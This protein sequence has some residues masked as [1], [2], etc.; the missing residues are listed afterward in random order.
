MAESDWVAVGAYGRIVLAIVALHGV[1]SR[2]WRDAHTIGVL[3]CVIAIA[4]S[5]LGRA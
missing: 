5:E 3:L 4:G 1:K 2:R